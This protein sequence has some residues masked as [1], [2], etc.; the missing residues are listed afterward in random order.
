MANEQLKSK[1]KEAVDEYI[2]THMSYV[3]WAKSATSRGYK[4]APKFKNIVE[5]H[6]I[7]FESIPKEFINRVENYKL[8]CELSSAPGEFDMGQDSIEA[9]QKP[10]EPYGI[11]IEEIRMSGDS[12]SGITQKYIENIADFPENYR[13][14][15]YQILTNQRDIKR[16]NGK[17][18]T[19]EERLTFLRT[20]SAAH[21]SK[22]PVLE[23]GENKRKRE[24]F[25][26]YIEEAELA[27]TER[28]FSFRGYRSNRGNTRY[29]SIN[30]VLR[31]LEKD[32]EFTAEEKATIAPLLKEHYEKRWE[33]D[34]EGVKNPFEVEAQE[35]SND[36][37]PYEDEHCQA[38]PDY[39]GRGITLQGALKY[40][41]NLKVTQ[42]M[43]EQKFGHNP[44]VANKITAKFENMLKEADFAE[45]EWS[46]VVGFHYLL[47]DEKVD[48]IVKT[49]IERFETDNLRYVRKSHELEADSLSGK[50]STKVNLDYDMADALC[51][52]VYDEEM[53]ATTMANNIDAM[54]I[55]EELIEFIGHLAEESRKKGKT[56]NSNNL[57]EILGSGN[58]GKGKTRQNTYG[59]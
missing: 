51:I 54:G 32:T 57:G 26:D 11:D 30:E 44:E 56:V 20:L 49:H 38:K 10:V 14:L 40:S 43:L 1:L 45:E 17:P 7:A 46:T 59:D 33:D 29:P 34:F 18:L 3:R 28:H 13:T 42:K 27:G 41:L 15:A 25:D 6:G 23:S 36:A 47:S 24:L 16:S 12:L 39:W 50:G 5:K 53:D 4:E 58:S 31:N 22:A 35:D 21:K 55:N 9:E 19:K 8:R 48:E 52:M 2:E 37:I